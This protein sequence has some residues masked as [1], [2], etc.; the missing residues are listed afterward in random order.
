MKP[1]TV[2][3]RGTM[4]KQTCNVHI[5]YRS[6]FFVLALTFFVFL[7]KN[8]SPSHPPTH[9]SAS[10]FDVLIKHII[11]QLKWCIIDET[12]SMQR[13]NVCTVH[14]SL[15]CDVSQMILSW[16]DQNWFGHKS[17]RHSVTD[18]LKSYRPSKLR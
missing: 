16:T 12:D 3:F 7:A 4:H 14:V 15:L 17:E 6:S 8:V 9:F 10:E 11:T 18:L 2:R 13:L 5:H 1:L